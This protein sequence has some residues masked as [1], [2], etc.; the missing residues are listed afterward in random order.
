MIPI[1][2]RGFAEVSA[3]PTKS[4]LSRLKKYKYPDSDESKGRSNYYVKALAAIRHHHHSNKSELQDILDD[5]VIAA[6]DKSNKRRQSKALNNLR[7][8]NDYLKHF[9]YRHLK[10]LRGKRLYFFHKQLKVSAQPD[11]YAE[12]S[13]KLRLIKFNFGRKDH[14]G[15]VVAIMLHVLYEAAIIN[16]LKLPPNQVE[17]IQTSSGS[18]ISGPKGGFGPAKNLTVMADELI[19]LW[20][21]V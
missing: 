20:P 11:L 10:P 1:S 4:K 13:G 5:L 12:E 7:A 3:A 9:S 6:S 14:G 21:S 17:C 8:I 19:A 16:G 15:A 2:M 18:N